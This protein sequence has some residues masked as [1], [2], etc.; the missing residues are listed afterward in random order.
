M[1]AVI[2]HIICIR[3]DISIL[4]VSPDRP[5]VCSAH[6]TGSNS[7]LI[8]VDPDIQIEQQSEFMTAKNT[9]VSFMRLNNYQNRHNTYQW[10]N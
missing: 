3:K 5:Q 6:Q 1:I 4:V 7:L 9:Q 2:M 10:H 8:L